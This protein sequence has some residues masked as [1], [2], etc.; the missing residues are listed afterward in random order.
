M[1]YQ[2]TIGDKKYEIAVNGDLSLVTVNGREVKVDYRHLRAGKLYSV[3]ADNV[4][5]EFA[6]EKSNGGFEA[7]HGSGQ[8]RVDVSDEKTE[9]LKTLT[10]AVSGR[11][12]AS[13][14][15][16]PM[17]GLVLKVEVRIGQHVKK[18]DGLIIVEAMK[19]ENELKAHSPAT[20]KEIKVRS[21]EAV[22]K[23]Q[24]LIVFE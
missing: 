21:G 13:T 5:Y 22:E 24:V 16:A 8:T 1:I 4:N 7:W 2:V 3:L 20:V 9:R 17:P 19:M 12:R 10:S 23:N 11:S 15:K 6:L 14:L 18:G